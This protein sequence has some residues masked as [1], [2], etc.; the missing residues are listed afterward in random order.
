MCL[1]CVNKQVGV[2]LD[3]RCDKATR[4]SRILTKMIGVIDMAGV[5]LS[6]V[7][8]RFGKV[9]GDSGKLSEVYYPQLL[10]KT[11]LIH[12]PWFFTFV[13]SVFQKFM[14]AKMAE[15]ISVC[16]G[17]C[18]TQHP[19]FTKVALNAHKPAASAGGTES[20]SQCPFASK[21]L[22]P[23]STPSFL[24]GTCR[25]TA[26]GGCIQGCPNDRTAPASAA[27]ADGASP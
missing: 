27:G 1:S 21:R 17:A 6:S 2:P 24:G 20:I 19:G 13:F 12:P 11:V 23:Q 3:L 25:C 7:D 15:K 16:P 18:Y 9:Q 10:G 8:A 22:S 26:L 5:S 4:D 14:S